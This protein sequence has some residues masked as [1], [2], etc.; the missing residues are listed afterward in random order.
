MLLSG[1]GARSSTMMLPPR[2]RVHGG[3][4]APKWQPR[5]GSGGGGVGPWMR[6]GRRG[7]CKGGN[8]GRERGEETKR[9]Q[10]GDRGRGGGGGTIDAASARHPNTTLDEYINTTKG[11]FPG[12]RL[13]TQ[14]QR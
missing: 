10:R 4:P 2:P 3:G 11:K 14:W 1:G 7:D 12:E 5:G 9:G 13:A 6:G 8:D